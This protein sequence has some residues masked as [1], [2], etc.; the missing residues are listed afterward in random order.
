MK[1]KNKWFAYDKRFDPMVY[2]DGRDYD[3]E[4]FVRSDYYARIYFND[5]GTVAIVYAIPDFDGPP[6][7]S[8]EEAFKEANETIEKNILKFLSVKNP[9]REVF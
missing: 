7:S 9:R 6:L 5:N 4:M 3:K 8:L 2:D 1:I